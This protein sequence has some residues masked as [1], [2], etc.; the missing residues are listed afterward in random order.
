MPSSPLVF[1]TQTHA[2]PDKKWE[3]TSTETAREEAGFKTMEEY[4][5]RRKNTVAQYIDT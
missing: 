3:Y 1:H 2:A 4:I 5:W